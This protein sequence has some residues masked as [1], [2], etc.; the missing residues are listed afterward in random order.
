MIGILPDSESFSDIEKEEDEDD[1]SGIVRDVRAGREHDSTNTQQFIHKFCVV[2]HYYNSE[3]SHAM[4][5]KEK[6]IFETLL[7][8]LTT[9]DSAKAHAGV[10]VR[11][12]RFGSYFT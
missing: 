8:T 10:S 2:H 9:C 12:R 7:S 11:T 3:Q 1:M 4:C 5:C 6:G